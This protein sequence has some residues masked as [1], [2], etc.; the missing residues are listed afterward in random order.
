MQDSKHQAADSPTI[1]QKFALQLERFS[2]RTD[3]TKG[4]YVAALAFFLFIVIS[5]AI[6]GIVVQLFTLP[7]PTLTADVT[8]RMRSAVTWSFMIGLTVSSLDVIAGIPLVVDCQATGALG[9]CAR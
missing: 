6:A 3:V 2:A 7:N 5:P 8:A 9:Y 1:L 4:V